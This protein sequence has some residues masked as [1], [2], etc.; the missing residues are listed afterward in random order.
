MKFITPLI[1]TMICSLGMVQ[2]PRA[3]RPPRG[4]AW[5]HVQAQEWKSGFS[6]SA[7]EMRPWGMGVTY[8]VQ[9]PEEH[10]HQ[11]HNSYVTFFISEANHNICLHNSIE[12]EHLDYLIIDNNDRDRY[13]QGIIHRN[14]ILE[15]WNVESAT[16][17]LAKLNRR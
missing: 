7:G 14:T 10:V 4:T 3:V 17:F 12:S 1:M 5:K 16:I 8:S 13:C 15:F 2:S 11:V 6:L 9:V